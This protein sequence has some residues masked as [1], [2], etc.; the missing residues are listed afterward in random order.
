MTTP[1]TEY[2]MYN[3]KYRK[4]YNWIVSNEVKRMYNTLD[5]DYYD[6]CI[7]HCTA[8]SNFGC[9]GVYSIEDNKLYLTRVDL[10]AH[11]NP[12]LIIQWLAPGRFIQDPTSKEI[13]WYKDPSIDYTKTLMDKFSGILKISLGKYDSCYGM[14]I[15]FQTIL[16][17][18]VEQGIVV[19]TGTLIEND[20]N[21]WDADFEVPNNY[22]DKDPTPKEILF[23]TEE[24]YNKC[25]NI[26]KSGFML[27]ANIKIHYE[28]E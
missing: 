5:M 12:L 25:K 7:R 28:G 4:L 21:S 11:K 9:R 18:I 14:G 17:L 19:S 27:S 13:T 15:R 26:D 8:G 24:A 20:S 16:P 23:P 2:I 3:G 22:F 10:S 1:A 6:Q